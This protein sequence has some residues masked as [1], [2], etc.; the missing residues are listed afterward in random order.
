MPEARPGHF[1]NPLHFPYQPLSLR[2]QAA[3]PGS[4]RSGRLRYLFDD[5]VLDTDKRELRRGPDAVSIAP[6]AFDLLVYLIRNRE[7]VTT[8]DDLIAAVWERHVVTDAALATRLNSAR[9]AIGDSGGK[10]RLI[11][12]LQRKGFRF[13][14]AVREVDG[15]VDTATDATPIPAIRSN[16]PS[17]AVLPF[18]N[19]SDDPGQDY[20]AD[21]LVEDIITALSRFRSLFV[22]ARQSSF[23]Y[24]GKTVDIKQIGHELDVRYVL[25]GSVRKAGARLRIT[26]QLIDAET[27]A[28][29]WADRFDG[30]LD[31]FFDLQ[32]KV[33][34]Q[35]VG[36]IAPE[37]DRAEVERASRRPNGNIDVVTA[38]YR[39]LPHTEF[40]TSAE[41]NDSAMRDFKRAI[42]LDPNFAPAYG[43]V[44]S[45]LGWR[46]ANKWPGDVA[47]DNAELLLLA[48]RLKAM[49]TDDAPALSVVG[50]NLF[51][52]QLDYDGGAEMIERAILANPNYARAYNFRGLLRA[53]NGGTDDAIADFERAMLLSPRD[54]FNYNAML[55]IALAH[56][57]ARRHSE[58]ADWAD[59]AVRAFPPFFLV[60]MGQ[61]ILCYVGANRMDDARRLMAE[62]VRQAPTWRRSTAVPPPWVRSPQLRAEFMEAFVRAGL[63]D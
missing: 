62:C 2:I 25:E 29:I 55:G 58:A 23:T 6:Q 38:F 21:G 35:V 47:K 9:A 43:G 52:F 49:G 51:W 8:K 41:N 34:R 57:N 40:P 15:E 13:V 42:A 24:K 63:P 22:I 45:C 61:A 4:I 3:W 60:G 14:G 12:T 36:A 31:D 26:G 48:D 18:Q 10:Q 30:A 20:F 37:L 39:G 19:L 53:W 1:S 56:H 5:F 16:K 46:R 7:R 17:I 32:D 28:H 50:F 11:K 59:T 33:T 44:A 54:P 27:G